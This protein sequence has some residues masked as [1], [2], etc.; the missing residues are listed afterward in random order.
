MA[1]RIIDRI[2]SW[3]LVVLACA[4]LLFRAATAAWP[5]SWWLTVDR[6]AVFDTLVPAEIVLFVD[7]A[8]HRPFVGEWSVLVRRFD[9]GEWTIVCAASGVSDYRPDAALPDPLTLDWWT[10]GQCGTPSPGRYLI[11]TIWTIKGEQYGLPD[12]VVQ[13][14]SNVF[15]VM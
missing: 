1:R 3:P 2:A 4:Y 11:S 9:E 8:I 10:N 15:E 12:K 14:L 7:R 5:A 6:V 13:A